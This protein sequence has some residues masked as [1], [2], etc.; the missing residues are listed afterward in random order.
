[1]APFIELAHAVRE[2][3]TIELQVLARLTGVAGEAELEEMRARKARLLE[4]ADT[5]GGARAARAADPRDRAHRRARRAARVLGRCRQ[6]RVGARA[7][8]LGEVL[9]VM[10]TS[11]QVAFE[12]LRKRARIWV[13]RAKCIGI[14]KVT[15][16]MWLRPLAPEPR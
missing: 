3:H 6:V 14:E 16:S 2:T 13:S 10:P 5:A 9:D 8:Y 11:M 4:A 12:A 7:L 1:M 15:P